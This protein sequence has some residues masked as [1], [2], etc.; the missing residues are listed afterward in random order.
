MART[1]KMGEIVPM[2]NGRVQVV[3]LITGTGALGSNDAGMITLQ[4]KVLDDNTII[5][6]GTRYSFRRGE[7]VNRWA[8]LL[9]PGSGS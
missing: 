6:D 9:K 5:D 8:H 2:A 3:G 4:L 7:V 1:Y